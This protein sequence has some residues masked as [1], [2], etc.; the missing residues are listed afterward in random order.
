MNPPLRKLSTV[1]A[2]MFITLM[3]AVTYIQF[4]AAPSLN[5]DSRNVR[6]LY[7]EYGTNRGPIVVAGQPIA[8]SE[9][10]DDAY[11]FL[12]KYPGGE[13]YSHITGFFSIAH[14]SM[15]G[16]E[17]TENS[18]LGGSDSSLVASRI[19][20]LFTGQ[21]PQGGGIALTINPAAQKA[22]FDGLGDRRGAVVAI[23][24]TTGKVLALVSKPS[25]DPNLIAT[26]DH[27]QAKAAWTALNE[28]QDKPFL[29]R[30]LGGDLYPPGSVFKVVTAA[31]MLE[32]GMTPDSTVDSPTVW[33]PPGTT[34]KIG[35]DEGKCGDGSGKSSLRTAFVESCNTTFAIAGVN[36]GSD[37]M[38]KMAQAFGFHKELSIPLFVR[39]SVFPAA[40]DK[41]TLAMDSFGQRDVLTSPIQM[42]MIAATVANHGV[43]MKP[44]LVDQVLSPD[45]E[46]ISETK[47]EEFGQPISKETAAHL[48]SMMVD[49]VEKGTGTSARLTGVPVA[50]KTGTA[51]VGGGRD[52]HSWF[53][54]FEAA[55]TSRVAVAVFVEN[56]GYGNDAAAPI[57]RN[58]IRAVIGK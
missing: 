30:A 12:R 51:Q 46:T 5:A 39:P 37:K 54:G 25:F 14:N 42:A 19:Q 2:L 23:E 43:E 56:G 47:P 1:V 13:Y 15:T 40:K 33:S 17:R 26:H 48:S 50:G 28:A 4:F 16:I 7:R 18:V 11:Q 22:A 20:D 45:L 41:P 53:V 3:L 27:N 49:V 36:L 52:A 29:N 9:P 24:P 55:S 57:A 10:I 38:V 58:V 6:T 8:Q 34:A 35:N 21:A 31:A 44:Y 32:S